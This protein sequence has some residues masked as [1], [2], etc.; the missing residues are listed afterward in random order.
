MNNWLKKRRERVGEEFLKD[1]QHIC[2]FEFKILFGNEYEKINF[3]VPKVEEIIRIVLY[4][5][6]YFIISNKI[7]ILK[8]F[9]NFN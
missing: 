9:D 8:G 5:I 2:N 7:I 1:T 3:I 6:K 4:Y